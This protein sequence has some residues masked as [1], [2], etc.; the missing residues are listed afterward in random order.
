MSLRGGSLRDMTAG[1][2]WE[3]AGSQLGAYGFQG[4]S[5]WKRHG[6]DG[7]TAPHCLFLGLAQES[8]QEDR[9]AGVG[10]W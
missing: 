6:M 9:A 8:P 4:S 3:G 1:V 7:L 5:R 10:G 2:G